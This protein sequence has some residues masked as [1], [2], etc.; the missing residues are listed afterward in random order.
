MHCDIHKSDPCVKIRLDRL[1]SSTTYRNLLRE[2]VMQIKHTQRYCC[3][4]TG[5]KRLIGFC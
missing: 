4:R 3:T 1:K 2:N 5:Q